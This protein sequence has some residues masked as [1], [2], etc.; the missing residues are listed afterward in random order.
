MIVSKKKKK[1]KMK[2]TRFKFT[3]I[4]SFHRNVAFTQFLCIIL[5][6]GS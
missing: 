6:L 3:I 1:W 5:L 2:N 4:E